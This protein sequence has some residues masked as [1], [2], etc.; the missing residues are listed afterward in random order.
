[1][2]VLR[3]PL[4]HFALLGA[5][6]FAVY[7]VS[8]DLFAAD[9]SRRITI[10]ESEIEFLSSSWERQWNRP[11]TEDELRGLV[12]ARIR[13]EVLYREALAVGLDQNDMVVRR[14]MVQKMELLAQDLA[15]LADPTDQELQTFFQERQ[16]DYRVPP[17]LTFSHVYFNPDS[18]GATTITDAERVLAE[19]RTASPIPTRAPER[20]DRFMLRHDFSLLA[21]LEVR[22]TF[23]SG[24]A[25][26]LFVLSPGWQG[27]ILSGY[28]VHLVY[29]GSRVES[30]IPEFAEIRDRLVWDYARERNDRAKAALYEGLRAD[31]QIE[32]NESALG[33]SVLGAEADSAR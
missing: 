17:R 31:Y 6:F 8:S 28:G 27:P 32:I 10:D 14:R 7:A 25:D 24:F 9:D 23:G 29:V 2:K 12:E 16:E 15:S 26:S 3:D 4:V 30:R 1:M 13:E 18:R 21:P 33:S 11:P 20:G 5:V 19:L 22:Q